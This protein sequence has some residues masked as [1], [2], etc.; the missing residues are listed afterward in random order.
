VTVSRRRFLTGLGA[1][2]GAVAAGTYGLGV[3]TRDGRETSATRVPASTR[4]PGGR[5]LVVVELG[6]GNDG[7]DTVVPI[8][9]A[10]GRYRDLRP[11]LAVTDP[12]ALDDEIGLHPDLAG[13]ARRYR[14]GDVAILEGVGHREHELSHFGSLMIWWSAAGGAGRS[15]WLGRYLD[16]TASH[17]DPL[18]ALSIGPSPSPALVGERATSA[19]VA[20]AT[21]LQPRV[22]AW[23]GSPDALLASWRDLAPASAAPSTLL[24]RVHGAIGASVS[25]HRELAS[26]LVDDRPAS[27]GPPDGEDRG[28]GRDGRATAALDLAAQVVAS[29]DPP[30]VVYVNGV[31]DYDTHQGQAARHPMLLADLDAGITRFFDR[32]ARAG[33]EDRVAL[34]TV[35][36]FGRRPAENGG[37]TDHGTAST[38]FIV[39]PSVRGG[40]YGETPDLSRLDGAGNL[41]PTLDFRSMY[42]TVVAGWL[43]ADA[44]S[45]LGR[46]LEQLPVFR[47]G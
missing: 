22:P 29:G 5:T 45:V 26:A 7:L 42:A 24:G 32:L 37:G 14:R 1:G 17:D 10:A 33:I 44:A 30:L 46:D 47:G 12:I 6:G 9:T 11:T 28:R 2:L 39:G 40:R 36:E 35:S 21:G 15:G 27:A 3:W 20:D 23:V 16:E 4:G 43:G 31:G 13:L 18:A 25:A 8:G 34:M 19:S 41:A 38:H